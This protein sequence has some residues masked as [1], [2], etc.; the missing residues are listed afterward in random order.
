MLPRVVADDELGSVLDKRGIAF[1]VFLFASA[2][3]V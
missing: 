1:Q 3:D 2:E